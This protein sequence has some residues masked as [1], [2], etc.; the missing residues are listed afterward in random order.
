MQSWF[1][2]SLF[3][4]FVLAGSEI[5]QKISLTQKV[6]IS[7]ITNN[8]YVWTFQ[9]IVG[10]ILALLLGQFNTNLDSGS[11]IKLA[12][13]GII[14]FAGGSLY[15]SSYKGSSASISLILMSISV[16]ISSTLGTI[17]LGDV[18][19]AGKIVGI[20]L[21]LLAIVFLNL[22]SKEK[23]NKYNVLALLGG[24]CFGVAFT[25]DKSFVSTLSPFMYL[26]LL[27]LTVA[28]V[29]LIFGIKLIIKETKTLVK[30]NVLPI[31]SSGTFFSAF[32]LFTFFAYKN[33][34]NVGVADAMNNS[35]VFLVILAEVLF[36]KDRTNLKR[37]II[38]ATM[39]ILGIIL[40]G[41]V[42]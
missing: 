31:L 6:S 1:I 38:S 35:S 16:V 41:V 14:Y 26:G 30:K 21:I 5:S 33:G 9:G 39:A 20:V 28:I 36:L 27:C 2:F 7:A 22:N 17:L 11:L 15:Y 3:S 25:I 29:S 8:F 10:I 23:I 4:I 34:A 40:I 13:I 42:K 12:I 18:F 19:T 32:N 24:M 37:K